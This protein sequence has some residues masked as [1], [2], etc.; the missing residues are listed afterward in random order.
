M[1][2]TRYY[3]L[4]P[5][6]QG[7]LLTLL[8]WIALPTALLAQTAVY[9]LNAGGPALTNSIGSFAAD[10]YFSGGSAGSSSA[11]I[12][13]TNEPE[14]YRSERYGNFTY[15]LPVSNGQ[16]TVVLH[17]AELTWTRSGQRV[18]DVAAEGK[19]V[20]PNYDIV[21]KV[22]ALTATTETLLVTVSDGALTL[23]FSNTKGDLPK[24]S[25]IQ[26]LSSAPSPPVC[27]VAAPAVATP[28]TYCVGS[29]AALLSSQVTLAAG[30]TLL[31]YTSASQGTPIADFRPSTSTAGSSTYYVTQTL[32]S[33]ESP[34]VAIVVN[35]NATPNA[36]AA[37]NPSYCLGT[38]AALLS[39]NVTLS[40]GAALRLYASA[41]ST[42]VLADLQPSTTAIGSTTY[43]TAQVVGNCE[44]SRTPL[45][46]SVLDKPSKPLVSTPVMYVQG[47][48]AA[49]LSNSV[50]LAAGGSLRLYGVP[51]GGTA[52]LATFSPPTSTV[53]STT[54]YAAQVVNSCESE[55]E[56]LVVTIS[57]P[58]VTSTPTPTP[59][60]NSYTIKATYAALPASQTATYALLK[61]NKRIGLQLT[62]DDGGKVDITCIPQVLHGGQAANGVT[63]PG[64]TY[65]DGAGN[66]LRPSFTYAVST[67]INGLPGR[68]G[69]SN[70]AY[71]T[72]AELQTLK[73]Y[74]NISFSNHSSNHGPDYPATQLTDA[75]AT[76]Q[77]KLGVIPRTVTIPGG[78]AGFVA[79]TLADPKKLAV[80]SQGYGS[81]GESAD[82]HASEIQWLDKVSV[83]YTPPTIL[84]MSRYFIN[85][86][87]DAGIKAWV[88]DKFQLATNEYN[89]GRRAIL[90]AFDHFPATQTAN[91]A[92]FYAYVQ[93]HPLNVGGDNVWFANLQEFAEYEEVKRKC[94]ISV[95]TVSGTT[96]TW[97]VDKSALPTY[98]L[99]QDASLLLPT[100]GLQSVTVSGGDSY[101]VNLATGLV[102]IAKLNVPTLAAQASANATGA[103]ASAVGR[104]STAAISA[105]PSAQ[106]KSLA[107]DSELKIYP[108]PFSQEATLAFTLPAAQAYSVSLYDAKG[109]LVK[110]IASGTGSAGACYSYQVSSHNLADGMY[111][112]RLTVG[113]SSKMFPLSLSR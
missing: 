41:T 25:A 85:Q 70:D 2:Q 17:F 59:T 24:V 43:Y 46:V 64:I 55:R 75:D 19:K 88:D 48:T 99:Y 20:L 7:L 39:S 96:L 28:A 22:G 33:C 5:I 103:S 42:T 29:T 53:G 91:L 108:N 23:A 10:Q 9:R 82:G 61:Y 71:A 31:I 93:R 112:V 15:A 78:F 51:S 79:A 11:N 32:N 73:P 30:A 26:V 101:S 27:N 105:A 40:S 67:L 84:I 65:T 107:A 18:F 35:V 38:S 113:T 56:A 37:A 109:A 77:Q 87:W 76:L 63:Y 72:W 89:A 83:P 68:D 52:L 57:S 66:S 94:P 50:T 86:D 12:A 6:T 92:A 34:R 111:L 95:P 98:S 54:Y 110:I 47:A 100:A 104:G 8:L 4:S 102:N 49:P 45:T 106:P 60:P 14:L 80:I 1:K 21:R 81:N 36:P 44:S 3:L 74:R 16:Y 13:G 58:P 90:S 97:T 69:P 62:D